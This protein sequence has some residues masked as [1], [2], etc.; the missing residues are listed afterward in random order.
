MEKMC[1]CGHHLIEHEELRKDLQ[2]CV[3]LDRVREAETPQVHVY[4][5]CACKNY[6]EA[7]PMPST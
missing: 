3:H 1:E 7:V 4:S 6:T 2:P 5:A